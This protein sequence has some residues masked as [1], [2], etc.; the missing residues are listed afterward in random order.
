MTWADLPLK[1]TERMLRQFS[2]LWLL[3]LG[4]IGIWH[5]LADRPILGGILLTLGALGG[6]IGLI[7]PKLM[8]PVFIALII[9]TFPVG[10]VVNKVAM[11]LI[12]YGMFTPI[13]VGFRLFGRDALKVRT[14]QKGES[15]WLEKP[16]PRGP[17][18]YL[19]PY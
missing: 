11:M 15:A 7:R 10:W 3:F 18:S 8:R 2:G 17:G 9:A 1:P 4:G 5:L 13:A 12:F 16:P 6:C 14:A 19:R